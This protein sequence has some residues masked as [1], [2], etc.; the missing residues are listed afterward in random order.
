MWFIP[1]RR[2]VDSRRD[3]PSFRADRGSQNPSTTHGSARKPTGRSA[4]SYLRDSSGEVTVVSPLNGTVQGR[5]NLPISAGDEL[6]TDDPGRAEVALAD[7]NVL[8]VGTGYARL[9]VV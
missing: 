6:S 1:H 9:M 4:Y 3:L 8:H 7:G 5:R 2:P